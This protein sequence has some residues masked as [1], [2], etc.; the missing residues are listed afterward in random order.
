MKTEDY[1]R[2]G[3]ATAAVIDA[4]EEGKIDVLFAITHLKEK[5]EELKNK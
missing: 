1:Q 4:L 2:L 5:Y 3:H